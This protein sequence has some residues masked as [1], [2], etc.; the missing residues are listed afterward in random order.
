LTANAAALRGIGVFT[1]NGVQFGHRLAIEGI[2]QHERKEMP[3]ISR[4]MHGTQRDDVLRRLAAAAND[5]AIDRI[6]VSSE[7]F[8]LAAPDK[9]REMLAGLSLHDV[10]IILVLRRQDR[11]IESNYSQSVGMTGRTRPLGKATYVA[12]YDWH[13]L[14]SAWTSAFSHEALLLHIYEQAALDGR[15]IDRV[16][17]SLDPGMARFVAE[18][19]GTQAR[20]NPSL[21]AAF[22]EFKRLANCAG[23]PDIM[24][25]L[26]R[27]AERGLAGAPFR[28]NR[29]LAKGFLDINRESN[30]RVA[31]DFL[32][33]SGDLFD[34]SDL[35]SDLPDVD[36]SGKLSVETLA[37]L[38]ALY[39]Q[40]EQDASKAEAKQPTGRAGNRRE[41]DDA[42]SRSAALDS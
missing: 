5:P 37:M 27:A 8:T 32:G 4:I 11:Y 17:G 14:A 15:I 24:P 10:S 13:A 36:Y 34:E 40:D 25:F 12:G 9:V 16:L 18:H 26:A 22:I 29:S 21:S 28:M 7:Y 42:P 41:G 20:T 30:R 38:F 2:E 6:I 1:F 35:S 33:L 19:P 3:D 31:E 23:A 39:I